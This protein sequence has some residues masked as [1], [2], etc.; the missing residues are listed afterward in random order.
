MKLKNKFKN[1]DISLIILIFILFAIGIVFIG[2][3]SYDTSFH[4]T[5]EIKVQSFAF[6]LGLVAIV[7]ILMIDY[8]VY[9]SLDKVLY[10]TSIIL[11]LAVYIPGIGEVQYGARSWIDLGPLNFQPSEIVKIIFI[12]CFARYLSSNKDSLSSFRGLMLSILYCAPII[13]LILI[14]PDLGNAIVLVFIS[15]GMIFA[16]GID[17]KLLLRATAF[18]VVSIPLL[19]QL[20]AKHQKIRIDAF[21]NPNDLSLPGNY[22]VW[23]SKVAIGSG[24]FLGKGLWNGTQKKLKFLPVQESDFIFAVLAEELGF[25]GGAIVI[26]LY[27]LFLFRITLVAKKAKDTYGT[28]IVIGILS[29]FAF[30]VFEN[31]GMTMG[32]MPVTGITLPFIS[33]GGSSMLTNMIALGL[34]L[35]VGMRHHTINF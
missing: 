11:L 9:K 31:I 27:L 4:I 33:Y 8:K 17:Y 24:N 29:M 21:L 12:L 28:L 3:T 20:M 7:I 13:L 15:L 34:V 2:S 16:A 35:N 23:N 14:E 26:V 18:I 25:I 22:Q 30:Q 10:A 5:R 32:V 19:Y 1:L 6:C